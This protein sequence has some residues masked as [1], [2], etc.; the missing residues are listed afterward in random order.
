M[1]NFEKSERD[2]LV[3]IN[4]IVKFL[5][6]KMIKHFEDDAVAQSRL[7]QSLKAVHARVDTIVRYR[8]MLSGAF[9]LIGIIGIVVGIVVSFAKIT[10]IGEASNVETVMERSLHE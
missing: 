2:L 8:D 10:N 1:N 7:E 5:D 9:A 4:T 6:Q 3:E